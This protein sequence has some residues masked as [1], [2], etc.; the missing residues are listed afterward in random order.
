MMELDVFPDA[1]RGQA[2]AIGSVLKME[3]SGDDKVHPKAGR[4][5]KIKRFVII[6]KSEDK[7][8][9]SLLINSEINQNLFNIIGPY[10]HQ[11]FCANYD[12]LDH[13]SYIDG[14][15]I[16]EFSVERVLES[17]QYLGSI[18]QDD[19]DECVK[20]ACESPTAKKHILVKY[21]LIKTADL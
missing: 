4:T 9:A 7:L 3:M 1:L 17:A 11:I 13:N 19:L 16:R 5:T 10:Q 21:G 18:I 15:L 8:V 2:V 20:H 12:F 14:Y 6:G